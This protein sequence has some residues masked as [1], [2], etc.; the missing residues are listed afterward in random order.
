[1]R[2]TILVALLC[3]GSGKPEA[4]GTASGTT[5]PAGST[6]STATGS[7]TATGTTATGT[8]TGTTGTTTGTT[9]TTTGTTSTTVWTPCPPTPGLQCDRATEVCVVVGPIGPAEISSCEPVPAGCEADRT[10]A[11]MEAVACPQYT[12]Q[13]VDRADN[14]IYCDNGTQ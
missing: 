4:T 12:V 13:C 7:T 8:T 10:C 2:T 1:M 9:S 5:T 11:C 6:T 3:C 14:T